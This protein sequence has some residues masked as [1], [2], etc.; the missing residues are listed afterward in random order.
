M[1]NVVYD[2]LAFMLIGTGFFF[3]II[4]VFFKAPMNMFVSGALSATEI[5]LVFFYGFDVYVSDDRKITSMNGWFLPTMIAPN[6]NKKEVAW[7]TLPLSY[8]CIN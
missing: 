4:G 8:P 2:V 5:F 3:G 7:I 6:S 1:S